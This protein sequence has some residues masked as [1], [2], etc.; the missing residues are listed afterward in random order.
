MKAEHRKELQTNSL[1]D[2]LGRTV[3][4]ARTGGGLSWF[5][6]FLILFVVAVVLGFMW[7][8]HN[9]AV[10]NAENWAKIEFNDMRSLDELASDSGD[11]K[12]GQAARFTLGFA[13]LWDGVRLIG[14]GEPRLVEGGNRYLIEAVTVFTKLA[15][16]CKD[17][18][19]RLAEAKY[20]LGIALESLAGSLKVELLEEA[21]KNFKE[22]SD[23]ELAVTAYGKMGKKRMEVYDNPTEY[24]ALYSFYKNFRTQSPV[25]SGK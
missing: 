19:E 4:K 17:D 12:Q 13:Y 11:S 7:V 24:A 20:H 8:R 21:K 10:E 14:A 23:G 15:E 2:F 3:Q 1:A 16:E 22:L 18:N 5:K 25:R 9:R 6:V